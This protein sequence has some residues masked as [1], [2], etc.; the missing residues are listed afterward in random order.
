MNKTELTRLPSLDGWRA[1]SIILVLAAHSR[2][3]VGFPSWLFQPVVIVSDSGNLGVRFF[4]I[5]SGF[6][7]TWL[8]LTEDVASAGQGIS[9]KRF[10]Y[11]R[12]LRIFPVYFFFLAV[13]AGLELVTPFRQDAWVWLGNLT[14][15]TNYLGN[16]QLT[17][18]LWS[19]AIE[20][21]FYLVWPG[22]FLLFGLAANLRRGL[23]I[24]S[25]P[26]LVGPVTRII[27]CKKYYEH[28]PGFLKWYFDDT[29]NWPTTNYAD[30]LAIGCV[31]A[32]L[33]FKRRAL[34][35]GFLQANSRILPWIGLSLIGIPMLMSE[36]HFPGRLQALLS[37]TM[38]GTGFA[39]L[40][41][42]SVTNPGK[43]W[44][45]PLNNPMARHIGVLSYSIYIWQE[46]FCSP[47]LLGVNPNAWWMSFPGW[48]ISGLMVAHV[49]YYG[50]EMPFFKLRKR[51]G[52]AATKL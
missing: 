26:I 24:L 42:D 16:G 14:F 6:L 37:Y 13:V 8:L 46:I 10:Y 29:F 34:V 44:Y 5:I 11:R 52:S 50:L 1:A 43:K 48:I 15:T 40:I 51:Y 38:Q 41:L 28:Y 23:L 20:E 18:H 19:L 21:Q 22:V 49:S 45:R 32:L 12:A 7:I 2:S 30:S 31:G 47:E 39:M 3:L 25:I 27:C 35:L 9:L 36:F 33:L 17:G 4:F